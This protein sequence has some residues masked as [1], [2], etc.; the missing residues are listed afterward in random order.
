M[1]A[2]LFRLVSLPVVK[3]PAPRRP[4]SWKCRLFRLLLAVFLSVMLGVLAWASI[5]TR[6]GQVVDALSLR[7]MSG[8]K[9]LLLGMDYYVTYVVSIPTLIGVMV[10]ALII[11][12]VRWRFFLGLRATLMVIGANLSTQLLKHV[13]LYRPD[14]HID[15]TASNS[16][17]SGHTTVAISAVLAVLMVSPRM[18]RDALSYVG[19][20]VA[21]LMALSVMVNSWHRV[22]DVLAALLITWIWATLLTPCQWGSTRVHVNQRIMTSLGWLCV[23]GA[24]VCIGV[25]AWALRAGGYFAALVI[26][27]KDLDALANSNL[28]QGLGLGCVLATAGLCLLIMREVRSHLR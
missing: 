2:L 7:A 12:L 13:V 20:L 25:V 6:P 11:A 23:I 8:G 1:T 14:F 4:S 5:Y 28:V 21:A 15:F 24:G 19:A 18:W 26:A 3:K 9:D 17:P 22:S 27:P 10:L 16:L